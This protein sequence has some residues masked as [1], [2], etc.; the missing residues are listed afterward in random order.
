MK[1]HYVNQCIST[2][3][4]RF[5]LFSLID[6]PTRNRRNMSIK[7]AIQEALRQ[8]NFPDHLVEMAASPFDSGQSV[9]SYWATRG[10]GNLVK[11]RGFS[12]FRAMNALL[13]EMRAETAIQGKQ[14][15]ISLSINARYLTAL[16]KSNDSLFSD[17]IRIDFIS[18]LKAFTKA[19]CSKTSEAVLS[20]IRQNCLLSASLYLNATLKPNTMSLEHIS[21]VNDDQCA[22]RELQYRDLEKLV[23][24]CKNNKR[25]IDLVNNEGNIPL[26]FSCFHCQSHAEKK[27]SEESDDEEEKDQE[28]SNFVNSIYSQFNI[29]K[30]TL[31]I[32]SFNQ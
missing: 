25:P 16:L 29:L 5:I 31:V 26:T 22:T 32:I 23:K 11:A 7:S 14:R 28:E 1:N 15:K 18:R 10:S 19:T 21:N 20:D 27:K 6:A 9:S 30:V 4:P 13:E 3:Q 17:S 8:E 24:Q 2:S 12:S